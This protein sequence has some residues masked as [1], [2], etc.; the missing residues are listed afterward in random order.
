MLVSKEY[1]NEY[2]FSSIYKENITNYHRLPLSYT[3][4]SPNLVERLKKINGETSITVQEE[5]KL[6]LLEELYIFNNENQ[7]KTFLKKNTSLIDTLLFAENEI[8]KIFG[9]NITSLELELH[10]DPE[11]SFKKLFLVIK[12][13]NVSPEGILTLLEKLDNQW[14]LNLDYEIRKNFNITIE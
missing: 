10:E 2:I 9:E 4:Y 13:I 7:I 1:H 11:E 12:T 3:I 6:K 14:Y 5:I 8:R